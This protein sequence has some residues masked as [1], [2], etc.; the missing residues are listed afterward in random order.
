MLCLKK[1]EPP[2]LLKKVATC[3]DAGT[4]RILSLHVP[5]Q[6]A[7]AAIVQDHM[8]S[9]RHDEGQARGEHGHLT[10]R[11]LSEKTCVVAVI[12]LPLLKYTRVFA[13]VLSVKV[14]ASVVADPALKLSKITAASGQADAVTLLVK[15]VASVA[16]SQC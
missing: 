1:N 5:R 14:A 4:S 15:L 12:V 8:R 10:M 2:D 3:A 9:R 6:R 16:P 7:V 13:V 11:Q